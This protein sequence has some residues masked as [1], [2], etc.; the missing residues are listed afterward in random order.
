MV[1]WLLLTGGS[2]LYKK[3]LDC[4]PWIAYEH[5]YR[6]LKT[7]ITF[8]GLF[9]IIDLF[10]I[11]QN[12]ILPQQQKSFEDLR[13]VSFCPE[14]LQKINLSVSLFLKKEFNI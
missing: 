9:C 8:S 3:T 12:D 5:A 14:M 10:H 7:G 11:H 6:M 2:L 1:L 13:Y 4:T